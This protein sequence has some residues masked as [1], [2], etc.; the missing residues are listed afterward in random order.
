MNCNN[1][2]PLGVR[3]DSKD[4]ICYIY[5]PENLA[6]LNETGKFKFCPDCGKNLKC[7]HIFQVIHESYNYYTRVCKSK[8]KICGFILDGESGTY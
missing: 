4:N 1:K 2:H 7:G 5:E 3:V 6:D 8:C